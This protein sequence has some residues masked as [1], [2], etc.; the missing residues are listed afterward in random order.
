MRA[1]GVI[2]RFLSLLDVAFILLGVLMVILLHA[3][4]RRTVGQSDGQTGLAALADVSFIYL[5]AGWRGEQ[6][7]R[8]YLLA[9]PDGEIEG[10]VRTDTDE[11][12]Q[13]IVKTRRQKNHVILLLFDSDGWFP[14]WTKE[15]LAS[16]E[17]TWKLKVVPVYNV[18][19]PQ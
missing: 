15:K 13:A 3:E 11:D 19:L 14:S 7:G 18:R 8:C 16:L 10:E 4:V 1:T 6:D 9:S 17:E 5:Y 2:V 12:I